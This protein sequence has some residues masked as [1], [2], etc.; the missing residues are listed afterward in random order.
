M[1]HN[2]AIDAVFAHFPTLTTPRLI[3]RQNQISDAPAMFEIFSD[4]HV[5][6]YYGMLLHKTLADTEALVNDQHQWLARRQAIRWGV[7][8][9][10]DDRII[11]SCGFHNF[12]DYHWRAEIGYE[13]HR[14]YWRQGIMREAVGAIL[15]Y[16]FQTMQLYR[17]E[18]TVDDDN[19][20]SKQFLRQLGFTYEGCRKQR[21][22]FRGRYWDEHYFGLLRSE[23]DLNRKGV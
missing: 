22:Y 19:A 13:L 14:A 5:M 1:E 2:P 7:T 9:K 23:Y 11:G 6:E 4:P 12:D 10:D 17:I 16:G 3:L 20:A 8:L 18:A 15:A 21:F